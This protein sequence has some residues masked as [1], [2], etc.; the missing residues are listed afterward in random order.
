MVKKYI[1]YL[2]L[3]QMIRYGAQPKEIKTTFG[4]TYQW[5]EELES[6]LSSKKEPLTVYGTDKE[7]ATWRQICVG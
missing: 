2:E 3:L 1:T 7:L 5:D 6:Y 4:Q